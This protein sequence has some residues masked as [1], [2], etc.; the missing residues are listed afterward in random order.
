[1]F[2]EIEKTGSTGIGLSV[3]KAIMN[4]YKKDYGFENKL[5]GVEF[6]FDLELFKGE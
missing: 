4:N 5:D 6:Y 3:V 1:M 2:L